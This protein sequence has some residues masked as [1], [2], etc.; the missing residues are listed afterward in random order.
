MSLVI[1]FART[2]K[3]GERKYRVV[4]KEKRS[5]RDGDPVEYLGHVE[6]RAGIVT[7]DLKKDRIDYWIKM[8]AEVTNAVK[9]IL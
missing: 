2:G 6:K 9:N 7:K 1:R 5:R 8:G 4:V 3:R